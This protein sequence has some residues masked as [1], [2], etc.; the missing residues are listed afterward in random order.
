MASEASVQKTIWAGLALAGT[1]MF[2]ANSGKAWMSNLGPRGVHRVDGGTMMIQAARPI[3]LG[4]AMV[5]GDTV[6]GL[7]DLVGYTKVTI[8]P[9]MVGRVMPVFT[10]IDAKESGGGTKLKHQK[11]FIARVQADG[12][13]GGF[14]SS[15]QQA[16][17]IVDAWK[18][19]EAKSV[20]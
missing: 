3:A 17:E 15:L 13:I 14:A 10:V 18:R 11:E 6:P 9:D 2:R 20:L 19:G 4:L 7:T 12:G 8:T 5:N 16:T 1:V